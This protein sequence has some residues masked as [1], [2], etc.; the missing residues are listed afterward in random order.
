MGNDQKE[1]KKKEPTAL[2]TKFN[3]RKRETST[4][5]CSSTTDRLA[6]STRIW[7]VRAEIESLRVKT[8]S[9]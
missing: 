6:T 1:K 8:S 3:P 5:T 4:K 9:R 2:L 7:R